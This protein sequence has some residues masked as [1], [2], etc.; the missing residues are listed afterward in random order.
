MT[1]GTKKIIQEDLP[2]YNICFLSDKMAP[3]ERIDSNPT[4]VG[5]KADI[6]SLGKTFASLVIVQGNEIG[7]QF[8]IRRNNIVIG[9]TSDADFMVK[10][11]RISRS[12]AKISVVYVPEKKVCHHNLV[13]LVSTNHVYVNGKQIKEHLLE[14]GD[15]I[16]IG[17]TIL[18]FA[19]QD[20]VDAKFHAD[21]QRKIEYDDLTSLLTYESFKTA[22][23]WELENS[24]DKNRF[25][26][27]MMDL[28]DFK[29]VN[30]TYGHLT[31]SFILKEIGRIINHGT[32]QFDVSAR[33]GGEEFISFLPDTRKHEAFCAAERLRKAIAGHIFAYDDR[34]ARITI[35]IGI[36]EF[37]E[38]GSTLDKL[39]QMADLMLYKAKQD[40][41]NLVHVTE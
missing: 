35:S 22:I 1:A 40:G 3:P 17:D 33:Y 7:K 25:S 18:K 41:K 26:L 10:D 37:P 39:V 15:K 16:Q 6:E 38:D 27:L 20:I 12:H 8:I 24:R 21:I 2:F 4:I 34:E 14:N 11:N 19:I 9:R 30:D 36:S 29:K 31:G 13:D 5:T 32:R 28:D 23:S